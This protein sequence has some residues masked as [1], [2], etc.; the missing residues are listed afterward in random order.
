[1]VGLKSSKGRAL[2]YYLA[3]TGRA[4]TRPALA[5]LLWGEMPEAA[6]LGNLRKALQQLRA[7]I[8]DYLVSTR[9]SVTLD[10]D[11]NWWVDVAAFETMLDEAKTLDK[12]LGLQAAVDLY[13]GDFLKGFYLRKAPEFEN[14]YL[15]ERARLR[16]QFLSSLQTLAQAYA[17]KGELGEAISLTRRYMALEP[18]REKAHRYLMLLLAQDGQRSAALLQYE[19]CRRVLSEELDTIPSEATTALFQRIQMD[20]LEITLKRAEVPP[21]TE[22]APP[23]FL[24]EGAHTVA[25]LQEPIVGRQV[26]LTRLSAAL[27]AAVEGNG[28]I[29]FVSGEAGWGKTSLLG[30]FSRLAQEVHPDLIALSGACTTATGD[31][32]PYQPFR[33][34]TRMLSGEVEGMWAA[35]AISRDHALRIWQMLPQI[36]AAFATHGPD[37]VKAFTSGSGLLRRLTAHESSSPSLLSD[38]R[39]I[40]LRPVDGL[41]ESR[42]DQERIYEEYTNVLQILSRARP[43]LLILDDLHWVDASSLGLLF[44]LGRQ[45]RESRILI[46]CAYRPEEVTIGRDDGEHPLAATLSEFKRLFGDVWLHLGQD[47]PASSRSFVDA[48]IDREPNRLSERFRQ[49]LAQNTKGHPLFTVETLRDMKEQGH[50]LSNQ[51]DEWIES[52]TVMWEALP[53][54]VEAVI[55][56]RVNRLPPR[57]RELLAVASVEGEEFTAEVVASVLGFEQKEVVSVLSG[58]LAKRHHLVRAVGISGLG[59]KRISCYQFSHHLFQKYVHDSIDPVERAHLHQAV[60]EAMEGLFQDRIEQVAI[61]LGRHFQEARILDKAVDYLS[62]AGRAATRVYANPEA[63]GHYRKAIDLAGQIGLSGKVLTALYMS[64]GRALELDSQFDQALQLYEEMERIAQE[65]G[66]RPMELNSLVHR[67][68]I[69][70]V[71][72]AVH[73]PMRARQLGERALP[74]ASRLGELQTEAKLLWSLSLANFLSGKLEE[75]I[76]CGENSLALARQLNLRDQMAQTLNDLGGFIYLYSGH[77]DQA[78]AALREARDLWQEVENTP[79]YADSLGGLCIVHVYTGEFDRAIHYSGQA[80]QISQ[81]IKNVWGQSYSFWAVG[82]VHLTRGDYSK[83]IEVMEECIRLGELAK[84]VAPLTYTRSY[85]ATAYADLGLLDRALAIAQVGLEVARSQIPSHAAQL[86]GTLARLQI[87]KGDM[88]AAESAVEAGKNEPS[89][90]SW[91]V[92]YLPVLF[93]EVELANHRGEYQRAL[94]KAN[95]LIERLHQFGMR[96]RLAEAVYLKGTAL[97]DLN[98]E[99]AARQRLLESRTIAEEIGVSRILWRILYALSQ[100]ENDARKSEELQQ[101][102]RRVI[103]AIASRID[104]GDLKRSYLNQPE[105]ISIFEEQNHWELP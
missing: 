52:P 17:S 16:E 3:V 94:E 80:Y 38:L 34:I 105:I 40:Y 21:S 73:D 60:G 31:G 93:A 22:P 86:L 57:L 32:D 45:I 68:T 20:D 75:A 48:L 69:Q 96:S 12:P 71:P 19:I 95:E 100:L 46:L 83:A 77:I 66:D 63:I 99:E 35:G 44:H 13:G 28:H 43:L 1:M 70:A 90:R 25:L 102:A 81:E 82:E 33:E 10:R 74:L 67:V 78:K 36:A 8:G 24:D 65:K 104:Q 53:S 79:M 54:R 4:H 87:R 11:A 58:D 27:G 9:N 85:L 55:E 50:L 98:R 88:E 26:E 41:Q 103:E 61:Q 39:T 92:L 47:D 23:A 56:K 18:W 51:E 14:W 101:E 5:G 6:A 89:R 42:L 37:L 7:Q 49:R 84:F 2:L 64:L 30:E 29:F 76:E 62:Q 91:K 15:S 59:S 97:K 72:T